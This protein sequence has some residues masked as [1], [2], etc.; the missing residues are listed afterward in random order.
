LFYTFR[1]SCGDSGESCR[2]FWKEVASHSGGKKEKKKI[3]ICGINGLY[4]RRY[5][6]EG[7]EKD[8]G[9]VNAVVVYDEKDGKERRRIY[10]TT[11]D[12]KADPFRIY[13][14]YKDR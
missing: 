2:P 6:K 8:L 9:K 7:K 5:S 4:L 12:A 10:I 13:K 11:L 1:F 3:R 14:L